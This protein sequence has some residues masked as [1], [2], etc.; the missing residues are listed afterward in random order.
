MSDYIICIVCKNDCS[1]QS[2]DHLQK[3]P[4]NKTLHKSIDIENSNQ[5]VITNIPRH[6]DTPIH[7]KIGWTEYYAVGCN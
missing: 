7:Y 3:I 4:N 5:P 6:I 1:C 2:N